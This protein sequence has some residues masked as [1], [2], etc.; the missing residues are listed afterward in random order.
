MCLVDYDKSISKIMKIRAT[1]ESVA[2]VTAKKRAQY[3]IP[4]SQV[5]DENI[6]AELK[7]QV[8]IL[9]AEFAKE[10]VEQ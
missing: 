4:F 1:N 7:M 5:P 10:I 6:V 8:D 2:T 3:S 9:K